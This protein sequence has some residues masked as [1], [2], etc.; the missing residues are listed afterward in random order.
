MCLTY[1]LQECCKWYTTVSSKRPELTR[2]SCYFGNGAGR[3]SDDKDRD[4]DICCCIA[5]RGV[6]E[7]LDKGEESVR[8]QNASGVTHCEAQC[9]NHDETEDCVENNCI[10]HCFGQC[11]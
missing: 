10:C 6:I 8:L 11:L 1:A 4:H 3:E 9:Q 5:L 7:N 2:C